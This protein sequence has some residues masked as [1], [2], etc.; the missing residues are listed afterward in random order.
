MTKVL[1]GLRVLV[2]LVAVWALLL[3]VAHLAGV[4]PSFP[5]DGGDEDEVA[6]APDGGVDAGVEKAAAEPA[7]DA[8]TTG[9]FAAEAAAPEAPAGGLPSY[10]A[11]P[12]EA[13]A[14]TLGAVSIFGGGRTELVVGCGRETLVLSVESNQGRLTPFRVASFRLK[15]EGLRAEPEGAVAVAADANADGRVDL[16]LGHLAPAS[17]NASQQG[18]LVWVPRDE[19]GG[20]DAAVTLAPIAVAS[21][22][23]A[24]LDGTPGSEIVAL[25]QAD[26]FGRR[27]SEAWLFGGRG[28]PA[29][30]TRLDAGATARVVRIVDLDRDGSLDVVALGDGDPGGRVHFGDGTGRFPRNQPLVVAGAREASVGDV[31]GD[32]ANDLVVAGDSV[33]L[34]AAN[35]DPA[36]ITA[37]ALE[38]PANASKLHVADVDG[39]G[40]ADLI[41]LV[42]DGAA[43]LAQTEPLRFVARPLLDVPLASGKITAVVVAPLGGGDALDLALL[44]DA[45]G[46]ARGYE[47][48]LVAD[49]AAAAVASMAAEPSAIPDA[50]LTLQIDLR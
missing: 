6:A 32:G 50:P 43:V 17:R 1:G 30:T 5:W 44:V 16:V 15:A 20:F 4:L 10:V 25:H 21:L 7:K 3:L 42:G 49:P 45:P 36:Q 8:G 31:D 47:L 19:S 13:I 24:D 28:A 39:D 2:L 35:G 11:C 33:R 38:V 18:A 48:V 46:D 37:R 23:A 22:A 14:P 34:V 41:G 27:P 9:G 40:R 29:R 12:A 26:R